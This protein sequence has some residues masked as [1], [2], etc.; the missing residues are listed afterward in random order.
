M[1]QQMTGRAVRVEIQLPWVMQFL[2]DTITERVHGRGV[3][4]LEKPPGVAW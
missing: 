3:T 4:L 1:W 2:R